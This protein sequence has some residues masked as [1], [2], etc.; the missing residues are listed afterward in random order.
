M[1]NE[2]MKK[3][4]KSDKEREAGSLRERVKRNEKEGKQKEKMK[5]VTKKR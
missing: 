3:K 1:N 5:K 4:V 2:E